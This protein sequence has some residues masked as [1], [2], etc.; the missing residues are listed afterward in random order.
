M[1]YQWNWFIFLVLLVLVWI[2][3]FLCL[4]DFFDFGHVSHV[5]LRLLKCVPFSISIRF[6]TSLIGLFSSSCF[7]FVSA[8]S[9]FPL[10]FFFFFFFYICITWFFFLCLFYYFSGIR[11]ADMFLVY[12]ISINFFLFF[13]VSHSHEHAGCSPVQLM[14]LKGL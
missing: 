4:G 3:S 7:C 8:F 13:N 1:A 11:K 12:F 10:F 5:C 14:Q 2:F 9:L 6:F